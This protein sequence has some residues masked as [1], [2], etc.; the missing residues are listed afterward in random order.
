M[1]RHECLLLTAAKARIKKVEEIG[2]DPLL[3]RTV[4]GFGYILI[5]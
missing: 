5:T 4:R 3:L 2:G 1:S